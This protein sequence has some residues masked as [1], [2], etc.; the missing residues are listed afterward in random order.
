MQLY[1]KKNV[2]VYGYELWIWKWFGL[3]IYPAKYLIAGNKY[4]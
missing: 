1:E 4:I 3:Q 2:Y